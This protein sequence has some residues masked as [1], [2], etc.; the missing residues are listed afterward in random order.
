MHRA[1]IPDSRPK[2][3]TAGR[4]AAVVRVA[5]VVPALADLRRTSIPR[6]L[7]HRPPELSAR[8]DREDLAGAAVVPGK[9]IQRVFCAE[10]S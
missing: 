1:F 9:S 5:V 2:V 4:V 8:V 3:R 6:D 10:F 7:G